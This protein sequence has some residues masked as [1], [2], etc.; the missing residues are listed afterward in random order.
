MIDDFAGEKRFELPSYVKDHNCVSGMNVVIAG[1]DGR[2][3]GIL[4]V[5]SSR[6]RRFS[7]QDTMFLAAAANLLAGAIQRRLLEQRHE[8]MIRDMRHRSGNLFSQLL[9]LFS[10]T[11]RTSKNIPDLTTQ[12]SGAR[13]GHG[14]CAPADHRRRLA[15]DTDHGTPSCRA[16][17]L[18][19]SDV[20]EGSGHRSRARSGLH[21]ERGAA[22]ACR[23][24]D[25]AW[26]PVA[27]QGAA[28][29]ALVG[30]AHRRAA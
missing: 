12:V 27:A 19:R 2:A 28:R 24:C 21:A 25:Q 17:S 14:E 4:G 23:Q 6:E 20:A 26:Q 10:Q 3:Y 16:R 29:T 22:R 13:A 1:R 18:S 11:A 7:A 30:R 9:A 8:L 5:C 15:I